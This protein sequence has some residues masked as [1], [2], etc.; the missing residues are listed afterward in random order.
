MKPGDLVR[1]LV[2]VGNDPDTR[3]GELGLI[4]SAEVVPRNGRQRFLIMYD[5][6]PGLLYEGDFEVVDG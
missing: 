6:R 4:L 2:E 3:L 5:G 1:I